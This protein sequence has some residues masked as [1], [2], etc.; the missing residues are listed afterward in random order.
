MTGAPVTTNP[1]LIML[2]NMTIVFGV[3]L[4]IGYVIRLIHFVDP[5][6]KRVNREEIIVDPIAN[7]AATEEAASIETPQENKELAAVITTAIMAYG[8]KNVKIKSIRKV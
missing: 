1:L 2:I 4:I 6:R 5:T 3:L 8:Y 7:T